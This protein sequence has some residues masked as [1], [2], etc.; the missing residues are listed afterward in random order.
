MDC[1]APRRN[2]IYR[3]VI[4]TVSICAFRDFLSAECGTFSW[5]APFAWKHEWQWQIL[6]LILGT[7]VPFGS[8]IGR[9]KLVSRIFLTSVFPHFRITL[10]ALNCA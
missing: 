9:E 5:R 2:F 6:H 10:P 3:L 7:Y 4:S 1:L 8:L